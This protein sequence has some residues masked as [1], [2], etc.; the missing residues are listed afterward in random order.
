M[1]RTVELGGQ[2]FDIKAAPPAVFYYHEEFGSQ[3]I[4]D[5]AKMFGSSLIDEDAKPDDLYGSIAQWDWSAA[6]R[7]AW[8]L[9]KTA[10]PNGFPT[11]GRWLGEFEFMNMGD[12]SFILEVAE[13][14]T[15]GLFR[16]RDQA[17]QQEKHK[18]AA[19]K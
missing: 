3:L 4:A 15:Q 19:T 2:S 5:Y 16:T 12:T 11:F 9:A 7:V 18:E 6:L 8:A 14:A 13:E 10:N 1:A 17:Q